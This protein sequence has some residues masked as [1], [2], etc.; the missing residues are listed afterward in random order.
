MLF[1]S[2]Q[3]EVP[4]NSDYPGSVAVY[5]GKVKIKADDYLCQMFGLAYLI[6]ED[7]IIKPSDK[8]N[9]VS[10]FPF[11][12]E[13]AK[14]NVPIKKKIWTFGS[15]ID[16]MNLCRDS[17]CLFSIRRKVN[18]NEGYKKELVDQAKARGIILTSLLIDSV[19]GP[20]DEQL[21][22]RHDYIYGSKP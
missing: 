19:F 3:V 5:T 1:R 16:Y 20:I 10:W 7:R 22:K 6:R 13:V 17:F 18:F 4:L 12:Q 8:K 9:I 14:S 21:Q 2:N 11:R 15:K